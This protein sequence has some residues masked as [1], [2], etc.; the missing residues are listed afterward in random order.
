MRYSSHCGRCVC[1]GLWSAVCELCA[2]RLLRTCSRCLIFRTRVNDVLMQAALSKL[3][4]SEALAVL[5]ALKRLLKSYWIEY[6]DMPVSGTP[7]SEKTR[8]FAGAAPSTPVPTLQQ[9][10]EWTQMVIDAQFLNLAVEAQKKPFV[11]DLLKV[12][13]GVHR[14]RVCFAVLTVGLP[15]VVQSVNEVVKQHTS[16]AKQV[17]HAGI[18]GALAHMLNHGKAMP[19]NPTPDY[20]IETLTL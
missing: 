14:C 11:H 12:R 5:V 18:P 8:E 7:P 2:Y 13:R 19:V 15:P 17:S 9:A 20:S 6:L 1:C 3:S 10:L 4:P 16:L